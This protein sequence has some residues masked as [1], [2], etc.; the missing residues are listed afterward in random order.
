M[1]NKLLRAKMVL[2]SDNLKTLSTYLG[3]SYSTLSEKVNGK[4]EFTQSQIK[5][6]KKKYALTPTE[7]DEIFF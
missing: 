7:V 3:I 2:H 1:N 5:M 6:I 4:A